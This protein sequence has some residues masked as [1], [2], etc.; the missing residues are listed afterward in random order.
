VSP[1][2][3]SDLFKPSN[4]NV[5]MQDKPLF[6]CPAQQI[7][8]TPL[9]EEDRSLFPDAKHILPGV[10]AI[11]AVKQHDGPSNIQDILPVRILEVYCPA[12]AE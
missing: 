3:I 2:E 10:L 4:S 1:E 7:P 6:V 12:I 5:A 9:T 8:L 11:T